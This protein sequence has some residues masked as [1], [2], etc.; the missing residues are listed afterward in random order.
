MSGETLHSIRLLGQ[1]KLREHLAFVQD[2]VVGGDGMQSAELVNDWRRA[3]DYYFELE[4]SEADIANDIDV[5]NL[6]PQLDPLV[7]AAMADYRY[8]FTFDRFPTSFA[9]VELDKLVVSQLFV[10]REFS[11]NLQ[12][13]LV[14]T[15]ELQG[16]FNFCLPP[17]APEHAVKIRKTGAGRYVFSSESSDFRTHEAALLQPD[18]IKR[19]NTFGPISGMVGLGVGFGSNFL[20]GIRAEGRVLLHNGYHRAHALRASGITHAPCILQ[21]VTRMD[22][23]EIA[24]K[25][26][27]ADDPNYYFGAA[28]PPLLKDFFDSHIAKQFEVYKTVNKVEVTVSVREYQEQA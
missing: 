18:D 17:K 11:E 9:M 6:D 21:T 16:L 8:Q 28:R 5:Y 22:E 15:P 25:R 20:T 12:S 23:L 24:V 2:S 13:T 7:Q 19:Y 4:E 3:N 14:P 1:P 27:V 26:R 10:N